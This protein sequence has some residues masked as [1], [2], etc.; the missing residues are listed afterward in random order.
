MHFTTKET[1][2]IDKEGGVALPEHIFNEV[3]CVY[4]I[5]FTKAVNNVFLCMCNCTV[6]YMSIC[7]CSTQCI[8]KILALPVTYTYILLCCL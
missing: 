2:S 1:I 5:S 3:H 4:G 6:I 8:D 7:F